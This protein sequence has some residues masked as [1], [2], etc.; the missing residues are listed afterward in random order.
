[1]RFEVLAEMIVET[2]AFLDVDAGR[3]NRNKA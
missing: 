3:K 2:A 1:V